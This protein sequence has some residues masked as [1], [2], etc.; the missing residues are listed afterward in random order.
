M[1]FLKKLLKWKKY[2][3]EYVFKITIVITIGKLKPWKSLE[4]EEK[5]EKYSLHNKWHKIL[6]RNIVTK[7][8]IKT[9][10]EYSEVKP[11]ISIIREK[12]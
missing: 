1:V 5:S 3:F 12:S 9:K 2:I 6:T 10:K 11:N 8:K 4:D 7:Q